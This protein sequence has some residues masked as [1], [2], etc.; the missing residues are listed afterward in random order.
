M[1]HCVFSRIG[2]GE[3]N[4]I[5]E[6]AGENMSLW[7]YAIFDLIVTTG[8]LKQAADMM[9]LT[10]SAVS[11]SLQKLEKEFGF[12]LLLRS[13][14]G[15]ELT[16]HGRAILPY[17]RAVLAVDKKLHA[18]VERISGVMRGSI[19]IGVYNSIC[20]TW[21]PSII[22]QIKREYPDVKVNIVQG[23]YDDLERGLCEGTLD[24]S[25]VSMP[26][27]RN[28]PAVP[29]LRDRLLCATPRNFIP[30]NKEY[31]TIDELREQEVIIPGTGSDFDAIAFM[32]E[33]NLELD[34]PHNIIEDSSI[35]AL[36]ESGLG[37][38][39][40]PELVLK[41]VKGNV[42]VYPIES[43]PYRLI[44]IATQKS[45]FS[46]AMA[47]AVLKLV[48]NYVQVEYA[49]EMPYFSKGTQSE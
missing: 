1:A 25:F 42:N 13:R 48:L 15:I 28:I 4:K 26:T 43:A 21:L 36:V 17:I 40:V 44:G 29:L 34:I 5:Q 16:E 35:I 11:H 19:R 46:T 20:C 47:D 2:D 7:N 12:P 18:E 3:G 33:N 49:K 32:K 39:I 10:A 8:N 31:V 37:I 6:K 9:N 24:V 22:R 23:G 38:T 27:K 14:T 30:R 45:E 41:S